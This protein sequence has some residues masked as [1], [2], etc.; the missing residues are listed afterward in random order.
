MTNIEVEVGEGVTVDFECEPTIVS[1]WVCRD[2][3]EGKTYPHLP[4][5]DDVQVIFDVGA[6]CGATSVF[7]AH[8]YPAATV[9][10]F[11]PAR[12]PF[13]R[14]E[15]NVEGLA[16]RTHAIG[17]S[18]AD[19]EAPFYPG[20]G[21]SSILGSVFPRDINIAE[22][23]ETVRLRDAAGWAT[24][25]G[26]DRIDILKV[27]VEGSEVHVLRSLAP[28]LPTVKVVYV[29]YGSRQLRRDVFSILEPTH[30]VYVG[31]LLLD[32]GE[33]VFL[34]HDLLDLDGALET[35]RDM[36]RAAMT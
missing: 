25:H 12:S 16:V 30:E 4:F 34:R 7:F 13:A 15:R 29:E 24:E 6:N 11:E 27:D 1:A 9:H 33:C 18:D 22:A 28:L 26:I 21:S 10:S 36:Y 5:V 23:S 14:L 35:L 31:R 8:K 2:I 17:L 32:Q 19:G 3:L 20:D